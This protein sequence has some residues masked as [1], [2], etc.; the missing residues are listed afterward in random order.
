MIREPSKGG[1]SPLPNAPCVLVVDD[2]PSICRALAI[3]LS[4]AGYRAL[5]AESGEHAERL[6][7][8]QPVDAMLVDLR[9]PDVRGDVLFHTA[10]S[11]QPHL[12]HRTLFLTGDV[13]ARARAL[14]D[15]CGCPVMGKPFELSEVLGF[16]QRF[17]PLRESASA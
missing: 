14:T 11:L 3:A 13:T 5:T 4:R 12:L 2:E 17:A 15:A 7:R 1:R 9:I 10:V 8:E 16:V 6:L